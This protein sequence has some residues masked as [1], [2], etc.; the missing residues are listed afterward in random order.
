MVALQQGEMNVAGVM[1][2]GFPRELARAP[3][4]VAV[5]GPLSDPAPFPIREHPV[6]R[7]GGDRQPDHP[8]FRAALVIPVFP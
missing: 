4:C 1:S 6:F 7:G 2:D 5:D 3:T 8:A